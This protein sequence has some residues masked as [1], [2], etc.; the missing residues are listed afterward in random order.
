[1]NVLCAD[2]V[3]VPGWHVCTEWRAM[4]ESRMTE[5]LRV[6]RVSCVPHGHSSTRWPGKPAPS[7][8][9]ATDRSPSWTGA[10]TWMRSGPFPLWRQVP[11][12]W[13]CAGELV[14]GLCSCPSRGDQTA[15]SVLLALKSLGCDTSPHSHATLY[16]CSIRCTTL[17]RIFRLTRPLATLPALLLSVKTDWG[18][19]YLQTHAVKV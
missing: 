18:A 12:G 19:H 9:A 1:M 13:L 3:A 8:G 2:V 14:Q 6:G 7:L 15:F 10:L 5:C 17:L 16:V 4:A 11:E